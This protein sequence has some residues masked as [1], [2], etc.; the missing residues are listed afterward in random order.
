[1]RTKLGGGRVSQGSF[2][3]STRMKDMTA[4]TAFLSQYLLYIKSFTFPPPLFLFL[5]LA[6]CILT[7]SRPITYLHSLC[8]ISFILNLTQIILSA[9]TSTPINI[10]PCRIYFNNV[11]LICM[12]T[13]TYSS[14]A[15]LSCHFTSIAA[16]SVWC[17]IISCLMY[18]YV[19]LHSKS[20]LKFSRPEVSNTLGLD[21]I[22]IAVA[23]QISRANIFPLSPKKKKKKKWHLVI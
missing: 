14:Y 11:T 4:V 3:P 16:V 13:R 1:M 15:H 7:P 22:C 8:H 23:F 19:S 18:F 10:H 21:W 2:I 20:V 12:S 6:S 17:F 5:H 9:S